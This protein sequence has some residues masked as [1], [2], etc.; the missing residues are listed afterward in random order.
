MPAR[1][2]GYI[3]PSRRVAARLADHSSPASQLLSTMQYSAFLAAAVLRNVVLPLVI[4]SLATHLF[5]FHPPW[6]V[7]LPVYAVALAINFWILSYI[8]LAKQTWV[9][10]RLHPQ[11]IPVPRVRGRW[12]LNLDVM[13]DWMESSKG[14]YLGEGMISKLEERYGKT[15][16]TRVLGEDSVCAMPSSYYH[17]CLVPILAFQWSRSSPPLPS[18]YPTSSALRLQ[19]LTRGPSGKS[20][21]TK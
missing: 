3:N 13:V 17:T 14:E 1:C 15:V 19:L 9:A 11:A 4:A 18:T 21:C 10:R 20:E 12:P 6:T 16:N 8:S 5:R 7:R 2:V